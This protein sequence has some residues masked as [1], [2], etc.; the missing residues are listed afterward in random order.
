M[1]TLKINKMIDKFTSYVFFPAMMIGII[2]T[3][4]SCYQLL[5]QAE[6]NRLEREK[7]FEEKCA[8]MQVISYEGPL[9]NG[10]HSVICANESGENKRIYVKVPNEQN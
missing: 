8:P 2:L 7:L 10:Y 6:K 1:D 9:R 3:A 4:R 5:D